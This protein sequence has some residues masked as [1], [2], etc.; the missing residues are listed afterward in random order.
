VGKE[1]EK[2]GTAKM[3][4]DKPNEFILHVAEDEGR[5]TFKAY[6]IFVFSKN[7]P[8]T[9]HLMSWIGVNRKTGEVFVMPYRNRPHAGFYNKSVRLN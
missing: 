5:D 7:P 4:A 9:K 8:S 3:T 2:G 6:A 1:S